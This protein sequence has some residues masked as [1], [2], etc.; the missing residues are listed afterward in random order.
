MGRTTTRRRKRRGKGE[1]GP[2]EWGHAH[3]RAIG[4]F[5]SFG[6]R[7]PSVGRLILWNYAP[8]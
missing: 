3:G 5:R 2:S 8:N 6:E 1:R 7:V 4:I